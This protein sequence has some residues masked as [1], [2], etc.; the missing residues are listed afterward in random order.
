MEKET[1]HGWV[2]ASGDP[3]V[4]AVGGKGQA[5]VTQSTARAPLSPQPGFAAPPKQSPGLPAASG[6][7]KVNDL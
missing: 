3:E 4:Y 6:I 2:L 5:P 1:S 7:N